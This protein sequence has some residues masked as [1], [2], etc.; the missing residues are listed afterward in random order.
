MGTSVAAWAVSSSPLLA[1]ASQQSSERLV[2]PQGA[3]IPMVW[4]NLYGVSH[5]SVHMETLKAK[6]ESPRVSIQVSSDSSTRIGAPSGEN[7]PVKELMECLEVAA[8]K[9]AEVGISYR[10]L[11]SGEM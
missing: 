1:G 11:H 8:K 6:L 3:R 2:L 4:R 9:G 5:G 7:L 10:K